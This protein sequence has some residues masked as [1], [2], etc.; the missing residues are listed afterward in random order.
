MAVQGF[1]SRALEQFYKDGNARKLPK[2]QLAKIEDI[3]MQLADDE[4]IET[5]RAKPGYRLHRLKGG[6][7]GVWA[8]R[9]TGNWRITFRIDRDGNVY[10]I[11]L[12]DY[13]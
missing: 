9:V 13:H 3:L 6:E 1:K 5:L 8:V 10:G 12:I 11:D 2:Q 4:P 7:R